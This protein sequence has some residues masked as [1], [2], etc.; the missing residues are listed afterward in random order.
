MIAGQ[1]LAKVLNDAI[2]NSL[3]VSKFRKISFTVLTLGFLMIS[4]AS[5]AE[6]VPKR[7]IILRHGEKKNGYELCNIGQQRSLALRDY[8]LGKGAANSLFAEGTGPDAIFATTLHCLELISPT[9]QSWNMPIQLF[10]VVPLKGLSKARETRQ[11][12]SRTREVAHELLNNPSYHGKTVVV[13]WE[14]DHIAKKKLEQQ[15]PNEEVTLRQLLHLDDLANVPENWEGNN[16]DYFWI[17]DYDN[18][19]SLIPT[20]FTT[21]KQRFPVPYQNVPSNNWG[22]P[23]GLS[24]NSS[25][26]K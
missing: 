18:L 14:H 8:Y 5:V 13:V 3:C 2:C 12:N 10:S 17:V 6:A 7:I 19:D 4:L 26:K 9:A 1:R 22:K 11:L 20:S 24:P 21:H 15:F 25:C 16:Y 23:E